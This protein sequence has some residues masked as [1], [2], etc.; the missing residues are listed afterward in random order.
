MMKNESMKI[1]ALDL[2][3]NTFLMLIARIS[4]RGI[5]E[6]L[7]DEVQMTRLGKG[8][9]ENRAFHRD[10]LFRADQCFKNYASIIKNHGVDKVIA[11][12]TSAARDVKNQSDFLAL[13]QKWG[14]P[15][16]IIS[17]DEEARLTYKGATFDLENPHEYTVVDVGG[18]S[19]EVLGFYGNHCG[20]D[21]LRVHRNDLN[22]PKLCSDRDDLDKRKPLGKQW[23]E[24]LSG[25]SI[26]VGSVR[27]TEMFIKNDPITKREL[28]RLDAYICERWEEK[29]LQ[30]PRSSKIVAVAGTPTTLAAVIQRTK[31]SEERIHGFLL[32]LEQMAKYRQT[33]AEQPFHKRQKLPGMEPGRADVIVAGVSILKKFT[34]LLGAQQVRVS[35]KGL[36]YGLAFVF[37]G[38]CTTNSLADSSQQGA[39]FSTSSSISSSTLSSVILKKS[40]LKI[41][42]QILTVELADTPQKRYLG[43]MHR[44]KLEAQSGMLFIF[45]RESIQ[46]FWMKNTFIDL[47]IGFF[48]KK[49]ILVDIQAMKGLRS[50]AQKKIPKVS[51]RVPAQ[52]ALEV[53]MGWFKKNQIKLGSRFLW[54]KPRHSSKR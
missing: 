38:A 43:L 32:T 27:L 14:I 46:N 35:T 37:L 6:V 21:Q 16:S 5:E 3:S 41:R 25:G 48:N 23:G 1:A 34:E 49:K 30:L 36:R 45:G 28:S 17:G 22:E 40:K 7:A 29:A 54:M 8:V 50:I 52:F 20:E 15:I 44:N 26:D 2:G 24:Q 10:T 12:A 39:V 13:G 11:V 19:T 42:D 31:F 51:S 9:H 4:H 53:P 33:L 47:D 18:G